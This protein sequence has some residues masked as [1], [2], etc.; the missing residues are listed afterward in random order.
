MVK[1]TTMMPSSSQ[2]RV[3][4]QTPVY[5]E[6]EQEDQFNVKKNISK[7]VP[8]P[9]GFKSQPPSVPQTYQQGSQ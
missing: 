6:E 7:K 4:N 9:P 3:R 2:S 8:P 1:P 5:A